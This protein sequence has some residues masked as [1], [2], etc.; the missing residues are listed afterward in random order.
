[1]SSIRAQAEILSSAVS[2]ESNLTLLKREMFAKHRK[3]T[4]SD[5]ARL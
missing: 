3:D 2:C 1:M 4:G 5:F